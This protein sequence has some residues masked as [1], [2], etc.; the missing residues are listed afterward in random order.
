MSASYVYRPGPHVCPQ[1]RQVFERPGGTS[2]AANSHCRPCRNAVR[3][4]GAGS[5]SFD[6]LR[7][8]VTVTVTGSGRPAKF[9]SAECRARPRTPRRTQRK[10]ATCKGCGTA[11]PLAKDKV[12]CSLECHKLAKMIR[13]QGKKS[14]W[15]RRES[16]ERRLAKAASGK[17]SKRVWRQG[18]C[19][20]C[21]VPF[22]AVSA[23]CSD[24]CQDSASYVR[25]GVWAAGR[26][27][28]CGDHFVARGWIGA[29]EQAPRFC[30]RQCLSAE[31]RAR[32]RARQASAAIG[33]RRRYVVYERDEWVCRI[34]GDP[35]N[36]EAKVPALDAP[37]ID[38][39]IPLSPQILHRPPDVVS[40]AAAEEAIEL[41]DAYGVCDGHPLDE[42][43][44]FTLQVALGERADGT[45]A[46]A[47]VADF[48]PRQNGK[49]DTCN[50]R[51]LAGLILFGERLIIHTA[52]EFPTANE[53]FL[54]LVA[55]FENWDDLRA[56]VARIRYANG[57]QG[58][59]LLSG[60]RLKYRARTGGSG[61][62]FA[63]ADLTVYDE[64]QHSRPNTSPR[65]GRRSWPTRTR[66]RG[67]W[68]P[69]GWPLRSTPGG[70]VSVPCRVRVGGSPMWSTRPR[71]VTLDGRAVSCP[72]T[73]RC[74]TVRR[75]RERTRPTATADHRRE[76]AR[77]AR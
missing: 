52:H 34:C 8:G 18:P 11:M 26:C 29:G 40:L 49:N 42:S 6:C 23:F 50:A 76:T 10:T 47:T 2:G 46:A 69:A 9:C 60:Q 62:G 73:P 41:A 72:S 77:P 55:V 20:G 67:T 51:E 45:W 5:R 3:R 25:N 48:E 38:H 37:T 57:E 27:Q 71:S 12:Y 56:K 53:S 14:G 44:R 36:R 16:V 31:S 7:C 64:A 32:R 33:K 68:G 66:S 30:S 65:R 15:S 61:R 63:K 70:C 43:Q 19:P 54:R 74:W 1:C 75:G 35:V 21:G 22:L 4:Q 39:T 58:I 59:E 13:Y 24:R 17:V 28:R